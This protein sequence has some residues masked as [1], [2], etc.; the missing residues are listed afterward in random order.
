MYHAVGK[1]RD[2]H[3]AR[4]VVSPTLLAEQL[5]ALHEAKYELIGLSEW[6]RRTQVPSQ[7]PPASEH[8]TD[9][10]ARCAVLTFDDGYADFA[11]H[12][13]PLLLS[14]DASATAYVVTGYVG[15]A[16]DWLPFGPERARPTMTWDDLR[17]ISASGI[18]IGSHSHRHIELD[19]VRSEVAE[20][21]IRD[22]VRSLSEQGLAPRSFCYP[23]GYSSPSVRKIVASARFETACVVSRGLADPARDMLRVRRLEVHP[24]TTPEMLLRR[25]EAPAVPVN[26]RLKDAAQPA[27]R[28]TRRLRSTIR[29]ARTS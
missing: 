9:T 21:D 4:W 16:A 11:E 2:R 24:K 6:V 13:L 26:T 23:F 10:T 7:V 29:A 19:A 20:A 15:A 8:G 17:A 12:A 14:H 18:E 1:P 5:A 28:L 3:F 25:F 27:W 22:S